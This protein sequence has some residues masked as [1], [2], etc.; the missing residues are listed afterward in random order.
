MNLL[1]QTEGYIFLALFGILMLLLTWVVS[2]KSKWTGTQIGFLKAG[3]NVPW[4]IGSF[5]IAASWIWAPALFVS[6]QKS[7]ELGL[8]GMFWFTFPNIIALFIFAILAPKIRN[9]LPGGYTLP[10]WIRYRFKDERIHKIYLFVFFWYQIMAITVQIFVGGLLISFLTGISLDIV[11]I[12][13]SAWA[14]IFTY[15]R[16]K[17]VNS[18]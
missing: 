17:S 10:D 18:N 7:Y 8:A 11:M 12:L 3:A 4:G 1:T 9:R 14:I 13:L 6:V 2:R 15:F 5:S 16:L